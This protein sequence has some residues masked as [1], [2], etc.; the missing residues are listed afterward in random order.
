MKEYPFPKAPKESGYR[1]FDTA[2]ENDPN[3]FF[4]ATHADNLSAIINDGFKLPP[5]TNER[6]QLPS[7]LQKRAT[8]R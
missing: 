2:L 4:H 1:L 8:G 7:R 6:L 5:L 3:V